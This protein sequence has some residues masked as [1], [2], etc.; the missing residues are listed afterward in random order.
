[1]AKI[2]FSSDPFDAAGH[3]E[4]TQL[5]K[6]A[7]KLGVDQCVMAPKK[8][9]YD[10]VFEK[11]GVVS[12]IEAKVRS[13]YSDAFEDLMIEKPKFDSLI[14][15]LKTNMAHKILYVNFFKDGYAIV[16]NLAKMTPTFVKQELV[17]QTMGDHRTI[18]K[19]VAYLPVS[20]GMKIKID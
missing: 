4:R 13:L 11:D 17:K 10:A 18:S 12:V 5:K 1:M 2:G 16:H 7:D 9:P 19:E 20:L 3:V 15:I 8:C 14:N 6:L